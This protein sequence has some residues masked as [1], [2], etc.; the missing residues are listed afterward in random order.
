MEIPIFP[1]NGAVLF[2]DTSLPLNIFEDRYIDMVNYALGKKR[3]IGMIQSNEEG[4]LYKIGCVGKIHS[5]NE[6][7]DGRYLISLQGTTCFEI[8]NELKVDY[9]FRMVKCNLIQNIDEVEDR[10]TNDEKSFLLDS[11]KKFIEIKKINLDL[12]EIEKIEF[13]QLVKFIAMVSPFNYIEKQTLLETK[14]QREFYS[15]LVSIIEL[16]IFSGLENKS[17]N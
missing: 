13:I 7:A 1:L 16:E 10:F 3:L 15:K 2:P 9:K 5:F 11:F 6:T 12:A 17:I 4:D 8:N 14:N